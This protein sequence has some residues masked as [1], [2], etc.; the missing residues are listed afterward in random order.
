VAVRQDLG[1]VAAWARIQITVVS[2]MSAATIPSGANAPRWARVNTASRCAAADS[3]PKAV[4]HDPA[5]KTRGVL[6]RRGEE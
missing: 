3:Q 4:T 6:D 1:S 2:G 5:D